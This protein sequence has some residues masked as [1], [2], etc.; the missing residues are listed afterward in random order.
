MGSKVFGP[1]DSVA[2]TLTALAPTTG[3][4]MPPYNSIIY[5]I[6]VAK[7]NVVNAKELSGHIVVKTTTKSYYFAQGMGNGGAT[8]AGVQSSDHIDCC[9]PVKG[10]TMVYV[11][12]LDTEIAKDVTVSLQFAES[13]VAVIGN[14]RPNPDNFYTMAAGGT[15]GSGDTVADTEESITASAKLT[16]A[17][18]IPESES[19]I[20]Q[21]RLAY[22]GVVDA[23][24]GS[25][26]IEIIVPKEAGPFEFAVGGGAGGAATSQSYPQC[27]VIDIPD[28]IP[29]HPN[30]AIDV[31]IT[32]AE[33]ANTPCISLSCW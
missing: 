7:G 19:R 20:Y 32:T 24:A 18:L 21:I 17:N 9:I 4:Q 25:G 33:A 13:N 22:G 26:K 27:E 5:R 28:G 8:N 3:Y 14:L 31:K 12:I 6:N 23:K 11:S 10:N 2:D 29:V 1:T 30:S 16:G 15:S